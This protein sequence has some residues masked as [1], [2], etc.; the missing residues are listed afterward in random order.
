MG[1]QGEKLSWRKRRFVLFGR[2]DAALH[3]EHFVNAD[4]G[5]VYGQLEGQVKRFPAPFP[6]RQG[7]VE[8]NTGQKTRQNVCAIRQLQAHGQF[9]E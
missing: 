6:S 3:D 8:R 1:H 9:L 4:P 2:V 7:I 5:I